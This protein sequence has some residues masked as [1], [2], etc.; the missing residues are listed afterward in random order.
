MALSS[1]DC[2]L[3]TSNGTAL[4]VVLEEAFVEA[5]EMASALSRV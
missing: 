2:A 4:L 3:S 5:F 1:S